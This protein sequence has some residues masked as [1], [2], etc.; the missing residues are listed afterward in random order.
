M[1]MIGEKCREHIP[2]AVVLNY[3][4]A[5]K[6]TQLFYDAEHLNK[7]GATIVTSLLDQDLKALVTQFSELGQCFR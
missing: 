5:I 2:D 1:Q 6:D 7:N 4:S 3:L